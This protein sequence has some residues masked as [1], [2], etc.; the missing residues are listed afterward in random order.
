MCSVVQCSAVS[1]PRHN[2]ISIN[3]RFAVHPRAAV[4]IFV[5]HCKTVLRKV[6]SVQYKLLLNNPRVKRGYTRHLLSNIRGTS[7]VRYLHYI[8]NAI[9]IKIT[10]AV[11]YRG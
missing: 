6:Y 11:Y 10:T 9:I 7:S 5:A 3:S 1:R 8:T 2:G 4:V